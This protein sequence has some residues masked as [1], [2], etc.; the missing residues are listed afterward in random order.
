M[1]AVL[2]V[3][4]GP[5]GLTL[6]CELRR[7]GVAC[8]IVEQ[9]RERAHHSRATDIHAR[10]IEVFARLGLAESVVAAG[11]RVCGFSAA[12]NGEW[13]T[14]LDFGGVESAFPFTVALP[15]HDTEA[16][17]ERRLQS[18]GGA[19]ERNVE[20]VAL[21]RDEGGASVTLAHA[22]QRL[23]RLRCQYVVGCDGINSTVRKLLGVPFDGVTYA[24][25]YLVADVDLAWRLRHDRVY[26]FMAPD[27]FCNVLALPGGDERAR[28]LLSA[29][30]TSGG[31][32]TLAVLQSLFDRRS[33]ISGR[34][35]APTMIS[36]FRIHKRLARVFRQANVFLAGDAAHTC[37]PLLG[38]GMNCG[39]QD[40]FNLGWK[41]ALVCRGEAAPTLLDSYEPERRP[42]ARRVLRHTDLL[43]R[44]ATLGRPV[45]QWARDLCFSNLFRL[46][47]TRLAAA[48]LTS[49]LG[50]R[51]RRSPIVEELVEERNVPLWESVSLLRTGSP[52]KWTLAR[53]VYAGSQA[54]D[55]PG[56]GG[57]G[58]SE[59]GRFAPRTSQLKILLF[60][61]DARPRSIRDPLFALAQTIK[62]R[63]GRLLETVVILRAAPSEACAVSLLIDEDGRLHRRYNATAPALFVVRPD[64]H[65]GYRQQPVHGATLFAYLRDTLGLTPAPPTPAAPARPE[66]G[67][68]IESTPAVLTPGR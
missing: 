9:R 52:R 35:H 27:G 66:H 68:Y 62:A 29:P 22:N 46:R 28:I 4:A 56:D 49:G 25:R 16:L 1:A 41:L 65:V 33:P 47:S 45:L 19:I 42:V 63:Y 30:G 13:L 51:Y 53:V 24:H 34:L 2:V 39:I 40:A 31:S 32:D 55:L 12:A 26:L 54:P 8:R 44:A 43:H 36:S 57:R 60:A 18:L 7:R 5:T 23:E 10:T 11:K 38:Q 61:G 20:L 6:A 59:A 37:S 21:A 64:G 50:L 67:A 17:L 3:G 15:Q 48:N 14:N 58:K